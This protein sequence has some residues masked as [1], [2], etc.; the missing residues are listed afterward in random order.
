MLSSSKPQ[1]DNSKISE[2]Q[3][4]FWQF[5]RSDSVL[6]L[7]ALADILTRLNPPSV[8]VKTSLSTGAP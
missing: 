4:H 3:G 2:S 7:A 5:V 6:V 8:L 1:R